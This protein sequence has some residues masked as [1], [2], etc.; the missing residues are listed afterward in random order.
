MSRTT[1]SDTQM[2]PARAGFLHG[3]EKS[4]LPNPRLAD[5]DQG[6]AATRGRALA[7]SGDRGQLGLPPDHFA[8]TVLLSNWI[9]VR[10]IHAQPATIAMRWN[11]PTGA[12]GHDPVASMTAAVFDA[13]KLIGMRMPV[14]IE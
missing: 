10:V 7:D 6:G 12:F 4:S 13:T 14:A 2:P 5:Q 3:C 8:H 1:G 9:A 11:R